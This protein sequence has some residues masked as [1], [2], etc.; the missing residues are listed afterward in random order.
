MLA[1]LMLALRS[2]NCRTD[3][4]KLYSV[5]LMKMYFSD[6]LEEYA[7]DDYLKSGKC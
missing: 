2:Y 3:V 6:N 7:S 4:G 5:L 1:K